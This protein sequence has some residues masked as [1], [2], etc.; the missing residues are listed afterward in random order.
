M[1]KNDL[2]QIREV[3]H[4]EVASEVSPLKKDIDILKKNIG[5]LQKD[6]K[7]IDKK[8]DQTI[9]FFDKEHLELKDRVKTAERQLGISPLF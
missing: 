2:S 1:T 5:T 7:K 9:N 8:L 4:E 6:V 3:I